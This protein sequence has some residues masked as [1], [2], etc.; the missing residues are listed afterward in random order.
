MLPV[1]GPLLLS[2]INEEVKSNNPLQMMPK[3]FRIKEPD[4]QSILQDVDTMV[5]WFDYC[6]LEF[7]PDKCVTMSVNS[8]EGSN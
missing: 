8:T 6:L 3:F 4:D 1:L 2:F 7:Y 5:I